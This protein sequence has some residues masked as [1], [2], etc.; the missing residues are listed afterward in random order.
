MKIEFEARF[1]ISNKEDL[2]KKI[3]NNGFEN[4]Q[5]ECLMKRYV[6]TIPGKNNDYYARVRDEGNRIT[7][8]AKY[9]SSDSVDGVKKAE[10]EVSNFDDAHA[11]FTMIGLQKK[12]Y[13]ETKR[14]HWK[15]GTIGLMLDS[16]PGLPNFIEI[17]AQTEQQVR[18]T[19]TLLGFD[20]KDASF[21]AIDGLYEKYLGWS[22]EDINACPEIM[23]SNPPQSKI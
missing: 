17:E 6:Y 15:K 2:L 8:T 21:G 19:A 9:V 5:P 11:L 18:E 23:F 10:I 4:V 20:W 1:I 16:W 7:A 14:A 3:Q 22:R 13:Q 12:G